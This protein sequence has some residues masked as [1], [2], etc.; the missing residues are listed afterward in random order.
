MDSQVANFH[1]KSQW[2]DVK[3]AELDSTSSGGFKVCNHASADHLLK[4][5]GGCVPKEAGDDEQQKQ[6]RDKAVFSEFLQPAPE[7]FH[8]L[9]SGCG[10]LEI[11]IRICA[12][13]RN[14]SSQ[15][16]SA[17]LIFC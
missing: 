15:D 14:V 6:E 10:G 3:T 7:R 2:D 1:L 8:C 16:A 9:W 12:W 11:K 4:G 17:S 13:A 5:F